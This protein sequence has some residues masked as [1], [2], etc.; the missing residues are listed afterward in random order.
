MG[1][2]IVRRASQGLVVL[3]GVA[4]LAFGILR[5]SGDPVAL[6]LPPQATAEEVERLRQQLNLDKSVG[7]QYVTYLRNLVTGDL[8][9]S[10]F[11]QY[12]VLN[13]TLERLPYTLALAAAT[14]LVVIVVGVPLGVIAATHARGPLDRAIVAFVVSAQAVPVFVIGTLL[15]MVFS[16]Q[17]RWLPSSGAG[18]AT[19]LILPVA[20]LGMYSMG[21]TVRLVRSGMTAALRE[22]YIA[23]ARAKGVG[24]SVVLFKHAL[25]N[26]LIP[27]V[28][29]VGLE[30]GGLFGRAVV[31]EVVFAWPGLGRLIVDSALGRD[32]AVAQGGMIVL[33]GAYVLINLS[34]DVLYRVIDPRL[35]V[36]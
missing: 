21:R 36:R 35:R 20:A 4:T 34:V 33:A 23:V 24:E 12:P 13:L 16:V 25:R 3:L 27:V 1:G 11:S 28:T 6:L 29:M 32:Y 2:F 7:R 14:L 10:F 9:L 5:L 15:I 8:G 26:V 31:I 17:L 30:A 18:G 22:E 19:A